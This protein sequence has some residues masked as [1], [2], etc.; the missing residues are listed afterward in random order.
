[1]GS[2]IFAGTLIN[3]RWV[4]ESRRILSEASLHIRNTTHIG[5]YLNNFILWDKGSIR[6]F[7]TYHSSGYKLNI[8]RLIKRKERKENKHTSNA[9]IGGSIPFNIFTERF[10]K[11]RKAC[12][13]MK[14]SKPVFFC[15][16][17]FAEADQLCNRDGMSSTLWDASCSSSNWSLDDDDAFK[18]DEIGV[19]E[20]GKSAYSGVMAVKAP[21]D[22]MEDGENEAV[23]MF[24]VQPR[25][26]KTLADNISNK[27]T[28][29]WKPGFFVRS[30]SL[31]SECIPQHMSC[32]G[33]GYM[34]I[35][36][37]AW[38][39]SGTKKPEHCVAYLAVNRGFFWQVSLSMFKGLWH[40]TTA[41][42][43]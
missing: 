8:M 34:Y 15:T 23:A 40:S 32:P 21:L 20:I 7:H 4:W 14:S 22:D 41:G 11:L 36:I 26:P 28:V 29:L 16:T 31:L 33:P 39:S 6:I 30:K 1:M 12:E 17:S 42:S 9:V 19:W 37:V 24:N 13:T 27:A 25:C 10:I 3:N 35:E 18:P 5:Y 43:R 38:P 2:G